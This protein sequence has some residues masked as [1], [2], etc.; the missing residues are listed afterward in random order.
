M[1]VRRVVA[2]KLRADSD[3]KS[4]RR[5]TGTETAMVRAG[6]ASL[7]VSRTASRNSAVR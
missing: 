4:D 1:Y 3:S 6:R 7:V 2:K 5:F